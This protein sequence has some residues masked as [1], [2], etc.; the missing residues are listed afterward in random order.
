[1]AKIKVRKYTKMGMG[2]QLEWAKVAVF[3]CS[4]SPNPEIPFWP[5]KTQ[6]SRNLTFCIIPLPRSFKSCL[7]WSDSLRRYN[8]EEDVEKAIG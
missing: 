3:T 7:A 8:E 1:M 5:T 4:I 2:M 6:V